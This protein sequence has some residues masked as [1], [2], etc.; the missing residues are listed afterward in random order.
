MRQKLKNNSGMLL[1]FLLFVAGPLR[2]DDVKLPVLK[3]GSETYSNV[4]VTSAT[5][6]D[7]YFTHS[8]GIGNAKLKTLD[9]D[10]QKLF[11]F[12]AGK[13][14]SREQ[15]QIQANAAYTTAAREAKPVMP[16]TDAAD[17][18]PQPTVAQGASDEGVPPHR[19]YAKSF[20]NKPAPAIQTEKWVGDQPDTAGKFVLVDFWATWCGPCRKAIPELNVLARKFKGKLI[21]I[22]LSDET[23]QAVLRM[24]Q[25]RI[26]YYVAVDPRA[27][28]SAAVGVTGIPHALL[29]DPKGIVRFE[30][31]PFYLS[32]NSLAK[33]IAKY[34]D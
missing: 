19:L 22:G 25:P 31:M 32:E 30:G 5:A 23:E 2:A 13:A 34:G 1:S 6:T 20:L 4:T 26:D 27:R 14:A 11:H 10:V 3:A 7:I 18:E 29:I 12:D 16:R 24:T 21:V 33:I 8:R 15:E 17:S 28:S 9:P